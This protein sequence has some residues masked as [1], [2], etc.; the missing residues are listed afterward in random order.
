[1]I[2][3]TARAAIQAIER[4]ARS[5]LKEDFDARVR[6]LRADYRAAI[7]KAEGP[8]DL[9]FLDPPYRMV[10]AYG[11]ALARLDAAG[12]LSPDCLIV[13][14]RRRDAAVELPERF[15]RRDTRHYGDTAVDFAGLK[16]TQTD[17]A[18]GPSIL[19]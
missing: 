4:N 16:Q 10:D 14:E 1:M 9:V 8:F 5:V 15:E 11:D 19:E 12:R 3:D 17:G 18:Q 7:D 2:A 13:M 6:I